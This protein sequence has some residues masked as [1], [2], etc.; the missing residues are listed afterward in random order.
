MLLLFGTEILDGLWLI[1]LFVV[2]FAAGLY[3]AR[4]RFLSPYALAQAL[5]KRLSLN[6][7]LSTALYFREHPDA[8]RSPRQLVDQQREVA[9]DMARSVDLRAGIPFHMPKAAY[10]SAG[11]AAVALTIFG[12][13]YGVTHSLDLRPSLV[14][15]AFN[16]LLGNEQVAANKRDK[17]LGTRNPDDRAKEPTVAMDPWESKVL[18]QQGAPETALNTIDEPNV[19]NSNSSPANSKADGTPSKEPPQQ[20][21]STDGEKSP[22]GSDQM[23]DNINAPDRDGNRDGKQ[24]N[25]QQDKQQSSNGTAGENSSLAE[26]MRDALS[27][28]LSKL[29]SQQKPGDGKQGSSKQEGGQQSAQAQRQNKDDKGGAA[30][31]KQQSDGQ[32]NSESQGD[33]EG[34]SADKSA[35]AQ[36]R[37]GD[38]NKPPA[39]D[40]KSGIGRQDGDKSVRE[41]EQQAAMGKIS[42]IIGKRTANMTGEVMVEVASGKQQLKTQYTQKAATHGEAGG[43]IS[44]DEVPL[45]YQQYVQQYF[46]EIRK[47]PAT[48]AQPKAKK[49]SP[50]GS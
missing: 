46:E 41:A 37:S 39:Q 23:A 35:S 50:P 22:S 2:G 16:G 8:T 17:K 33:Q 1:A 45:A 40:G 43:E 26:K 3:R 30:Q 48:P 25:R 42:E 32:A 44:R 15:I 49:A 27:N 29:K 19:D 47:L 5:D 4:S 28:L 38:S 9:E 14:Q 11:L 10:A 18:D 36:N 34:Q 20:P 13:R 24:S 12:V 6:D 31:G 21:D 7:S